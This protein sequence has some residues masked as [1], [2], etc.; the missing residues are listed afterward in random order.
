MRLTVDALESD[1]F[2]LDLGD[3]RLPDELV[4]DVEAS[5]VTD[6]GACGVERNRAHHMRFS[7]DVKATFIWL[8][9][10]P[11]K[12]GQPAFHVDGTDARGLH[13]VMVHAVRPG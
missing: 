3:T 4:T 2:A 12:L 11:A 6:A 7:N 8:D 10:A 1:G 13:D 5:D 9:L